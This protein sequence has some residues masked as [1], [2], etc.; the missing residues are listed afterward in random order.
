MWLKGGKITT[1]IVYLV[2]G[3]P[4]TAYLQCDGTWGMGLSVAKINYYGNQSVLWIGEIDSADAAHINSI[5]FTVWGFVCLFDKTIFVLVHYKLFI[6]VI[7]LL[8]R[9]FILD[10]NAAIQILYKYLN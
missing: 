1:K 4:T 7:G 10:R 2:K 5:E 9:I 3:Y 8:D 6:Q